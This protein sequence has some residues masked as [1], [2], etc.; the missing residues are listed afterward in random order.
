ML[1]FWSINSFKPDAVKVNLSTEDYP[2]L[3]Q[4]QKAESSIVLTVI[5]AFF[6]ASLAMDVVNEY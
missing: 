4:P 1:V 2:L 6:A 3:T 5:F